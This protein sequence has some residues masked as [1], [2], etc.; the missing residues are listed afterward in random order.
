VCI[1]SGRCRCDAHWAG[2]ACAR[3]G[4]TNDCN[5]HGVCSRTVVSGDYA[6]KCARGWEGEACASRACESNCGGAAH[7]RCL[8]GRCFCAPGWTGTACALRAC[9]NACSGRGA[10]ANGECRCRAGWSGASCE[11]RSCP[12]ECSAHGVCRALIRAPP[13]RNALRQRSCTLR[14]GTKMLILP[15]RAR[16][17]RPLLRAAGT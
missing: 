12:N 3:R 2:P 15:S 16:S 6:C 9:P 7:G 14:W 13:Q 5:A 1:A 8:A 4:C 11:V 17:L 10:C